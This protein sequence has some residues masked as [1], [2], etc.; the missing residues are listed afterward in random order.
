[1]FFTLLHAGYMTYVCVYMFYTYVQTSH[2]GVQLEDVFFSMLD[3]CAALASAPAGEEFQI[4]SEHLKHDERWMVWLIL[5]NEKMV[6][7][8]L[9]NT[10]AKNRIQ[11]LHAACVGGEH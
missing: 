6:V 2:F 8:I 7:V 1:M 11:T 9:K 4:A 10:A 3:S 5:E